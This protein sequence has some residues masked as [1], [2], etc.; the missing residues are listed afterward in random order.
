[1]HV[2]L[3]L[4]GWGPLPGFRWPKCEVVHGETVIEDE[5]LGEENAKEHVM[6][7][8]VIIWN[9]VM[10][11]VWHRIDIMECHTIRRSDDKKPLKSWTTTEY[12]KAYVWQDEARKGQGHESWSTY[13]HQLEQFV[14][15]IKGTGSSSGIWMDG[16]DSVKQMKMIDSAYKKAGLPLRPTSSY[17]EAA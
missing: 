3:T 9:M 1:M 13:R 12:Q 17:Q 8:K 2:D 16:E 10:P 14:H 7:K 6:V 15:K 4:H 5:S 11:V